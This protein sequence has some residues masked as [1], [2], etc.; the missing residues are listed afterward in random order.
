MVLDMTTNE[1]MPFGIII[2]VLINIIIAY[3]TLST[4]FTPGKEEGISYDDGWEE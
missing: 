3:L 2:T 1:F 4:K